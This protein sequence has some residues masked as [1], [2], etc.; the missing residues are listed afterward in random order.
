MRL[1]DLRGASSR[2]RPV[3]EEAHSAFQPSM[4]DYVRVAVALA[5]VT[6]MEVAIYYIEA[7]QGALVELFL[8][9]S[10]IKFM[11]VVMWYMH[12]RFDSRLFSFLFAFG[13]V[14][15]IGVFV[16]TLATMKAGLL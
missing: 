11:L 15:A 16:A 2:A 1:A 8:F 7:L 12:L 10:S 14:M 13:L 9:L 4:A 6:S 5:A 3:E